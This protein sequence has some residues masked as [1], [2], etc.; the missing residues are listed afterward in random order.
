[1]LTLYVRLRP[2]SSPLSSESPATDALGQQT[3]DSA[4]SLSPLPSPT[5]DTCIKQ[6]IMHGLQSSAGLKM[7]LHTHLGGGAILTSNVGQT[8]LRS[9]LIS[10]S[11]YARLQVSVC[12]SYDLS[13]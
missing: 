9:E 3:D 7:P 4:P 13:P 2:A 10:R 11:V 12:S 6:R 5:S 8:G 1:M